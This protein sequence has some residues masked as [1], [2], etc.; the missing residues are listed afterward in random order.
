VATDFSRSLALLRKERGVSQRMAAQ[1]LGVSQALLSHYETWAREPGLAFVSQ[2]CA[3]YEVSADFL[4]GRTLERHANPVAP[5]EM[6]DASQDKQ[7]RVGKGSVAALFAR[8]LVIN[9]VS[10]L[11]DYA[12]RS[13]HTGLVPELTNFFSGA[14]YKIFRHFYAFSGENE[15]GFFSVGHEVYPLA[16][17]ADM[18]ESECRL[19]AILHSGKGQAPDLPA[20]SNDMLMTEYPQLVQSLYALVHQAQDR[21]A[22]KLP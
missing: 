7:N 22:K 9:A 18:Q 8:K 2:A 6:F 12:G 14:V 1:S 16:S 17:G 11:F 3:Y 15:K 10:L 4:L 21:A 13:G 20:L 19:L 5:G